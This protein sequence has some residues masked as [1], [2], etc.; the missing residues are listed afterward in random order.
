MKQVGASDDVSDFYLR[1]S[2][3]EFEL[4]INYLD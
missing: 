2:R 1:C 3:F 4:D